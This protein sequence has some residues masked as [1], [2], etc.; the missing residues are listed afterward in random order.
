[1]STSAMNTQVLD[2]PCDDEAVMRVDTRFGV[3]DTDRRSLVAF[4]VGLPAFEQC[5]HFVLMASPSIAP[6]QCLHAVDGPPA[7]F[8]VINPRLVFPEYRCKLS[9]AD[10]ERFQVTNDAPLL[11]LVLV[12][13][14]ENG[15]ATANLRAPIVINPTR[16]V[17]YQ[18]MPHDS[19]YPMRYPLVSD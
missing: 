16:M 2:P 10:R 9:P 1:M 11:W 18:V 7:S 3:F 5:R 4:P 12:S 17:G 15:E 8:L 19:L 13:L 6:F 14:K